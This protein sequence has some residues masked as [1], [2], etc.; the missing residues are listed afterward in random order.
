MLVHTAS[1]LCAPSPHCPCRRQSPSFVARITRVPLPH[2]ATSRGS[3]AMLSL[4]P[5]PATHDVVTTATHD[6]VVTAASDESGV[7]AGVTS[8]KSPV[9]ILPLYCC[10]HLTTILL[11]HL[12]RRSSVCHMYVHSI[13]LA[14]IHHHYASIHHH[15]AHYV[16]SVS[17]RHAQTSERHGQCQVPFWQAHTV[18]LSRVI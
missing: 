16:C 13:Y 9:V 5:Y 3:H 7:E 18:T 8:D 4:C 11:S 15:Y 17:N 1:L 10:R 14:S 6:V 12:C 2:E